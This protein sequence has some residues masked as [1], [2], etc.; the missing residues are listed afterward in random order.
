M[1]YKISVNAGR[2]SDSK[3]YAVV[4]KGDNTV[5]GCHPTEAEAKKQMAA[6]YANENS[7][8][9]GG[10]V[11]NSVSYLVDLSTVTLSEENGVASSWVHALPV[12]MYKHPMYGEIKITPERVKRF[13]ENVN[14][15]VRGIDESINYVHNNNDVAAGWTKKAEARENGVWLFVEWVKDAAQAIKE[16]KWR[17]F[18]AEYQD[19]WEDPKGNKYQDVILGGALTNRPFMKNLVPI[20]LSEMTV[21]N[22]FELVSAISGKPIDNL[23]GG[24]DVPLSEEDLDKL[25]T[26]LSEKLAAKPEEKKE[27]PAAPKMNLAEIPELKE[28]AESNPMVAALIKHVESQNVDLETSAKKLKEAEIERRLAEFDRSKIILTPVAKKLAYELMEKMDGDLMEPFW[29]LLTEMKKGSTFL[30]ELGERAGTTVNYGSQK[31][32]VKQFEDYA[33]TLKKKHELSDADSF[34]RAASENPS[35]W[36]AYRDELM[37]VT[38]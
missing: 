12:G 7:M 1:P 6:L 27:E 34:E 17:Y 33:A 38:K 37:G 10:K 30:V 29:K 24:N 32:A 11:T 4:K 8:S 2:C 20:N 35:L 3:P 25:V 31:S 23:R 16:K 28:L 18:S 36:K 15:K 9:E 26:K 22:A 5:M 19:E 14:V 21:D 13:A